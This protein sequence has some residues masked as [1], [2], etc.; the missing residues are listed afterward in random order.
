[1]TMCSCGDGGS[2]AILF[3]TNVRSLLIG[4]LLARME[5]LPG[6]CDFVLARGGI[7]DSLS[8]N[9]GMSSTYKPPPPC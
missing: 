5:C 7:R 6:A 4:I 2:P 1:M 9:R 8:T 3:F